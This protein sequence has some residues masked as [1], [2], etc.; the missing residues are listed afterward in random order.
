M[1]TS[2]GKIVVLTS[3]GDAPGMNAILRAVVRSSIYHGFE[4]YGCRD[5]FQGLIDRDLFPLQASDVANIMQRGGAILNSLRAPDFHKA[6]VRAKCR[7]FLQEQGINYLIAIGGDGTFRGISYFE[8]EGGP[9][10]IG[11]PGS[12]DNDII[13]TEY[14]I[15]YDTARNTA[16]S[17]IDKIRDT[18]SSSNLYFLVETMGRNA[19]F[20]AA[21]VGIAGGAEYILT[22]EF[23]VSVEKLARFI[24]APKRKKKSLI[25]VVAEADEPGRSF[26]IAKQLER[27][28]P[29]FEFRVCVLGHTQRGGSPTAWDRIVAS[30][31][32][33]MAVEA[34]KAGKSKCITAVK[35]GKYVL[36]PLP[37]PR[38]KSRCLTDNETLKIGSVL[39]S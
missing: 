22:P 18:A 17:S 3:G 31:M 9:K 6:N 1:T 20:L 35:G 12:I 11:I 39:S 14:S 38:L 25:I 7:Q 27:M 28:A 24:N 32:G 30:H 21:D 23:P 13:G 19:G 15:G 8:K 10:C 4:I 26:K 37:N 2:R 34:L 29:S 36:A 16:L 33:N 5:G